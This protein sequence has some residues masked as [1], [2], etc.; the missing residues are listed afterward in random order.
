MGS[1]TTRQHTHD[2]LNCVSLTALSPLVH[3][4]LILSCNMWLRTL[5]L[6]VATLSAVQG[7]QVA[8]LEPIPLENIQQGR[9]EQR[10]NQH[11]HQILSLLHCSRMQP[12]HVKPHNSGI[13][14][15][16]HVAPQKQWSQLVV[17]PIE[18]CSFVVT[19]STAYALQPLIAARNCQQSS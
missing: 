5:L 16:L 10:T 15:L 9:R 12:Q 1:S 19:C 3:F 2:C 7:K 11:L 13:F 18:R 6:V 17:S 8:V 4:L 14:A